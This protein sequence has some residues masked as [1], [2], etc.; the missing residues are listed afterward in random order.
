MKEENVP[1]DTCEPVAL[2]VWKR[3]VGHHIFTCN[4]DGWSIK[5]YK[6]VA[7]G[8]PHTHGYYQSTV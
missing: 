8:F 1:H 5:K 2:A 7:K 3:V 4:R 6:E